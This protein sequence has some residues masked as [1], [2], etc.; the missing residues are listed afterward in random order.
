M[1]MRQYAIS[2]GIIRPIGHHLR[3]TV[4]W[5]GNSASDPTPQ[6]WHDEPTLT[7]YRSII[8]SE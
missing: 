8:V 4:A 6:R 2:L 3:E 5:Y 1:T 7:L